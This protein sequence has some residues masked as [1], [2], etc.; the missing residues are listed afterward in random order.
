LKQIIEKIDS[1]EWDSAR[2]LWYTEIMGKRITG[3]KIDFFG[4]VQEYFL[5]YLY[6]FQ[7]HDIIQKCN[8]AC[9]KNEKEVLARESYIIYVA[10]LKNFGF[11]LINGVK[12]KCELCKNRVT[13]EIH[14]YKKPS[15]VF[16]EVETRLKII[17]LPDTLKISSLNFKL[18]CVVIHVNLNHFVSIFK[19]N[20]KY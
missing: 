13:S 16:V 18:L 17:D 15:F 19:I 4:T 20:K 2:Q 12:S 14:F 7:L 5:Q 10:K 8:E 9:I 3:R 1:L 6:P 11:Q